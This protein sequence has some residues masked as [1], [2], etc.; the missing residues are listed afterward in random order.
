MPPGTTPGI[1]HAVYGK[2]YQVL[3]CHV[4]LKSGA[5][6]SGLPLHGLSITT[7]FSRGHK[8]LMP[9]SAMGDHIETIHLKYLEG[10]ACTTRLPFV[11]SGRHTGIMIDWSDGYSRY[12]QEHKPLN[13]ISL[14]SGQF[15]LLPNNFIVFKD[16]HFINDEAKENLKFYRRGET[17]Y[18]G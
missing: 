4:M 14:I 8:E 18:W 6:W 2:E 16:D 10:L 11:E 3:M 12:P 7:D 1:W 13:L 17:V 5:H 9:W 15:A